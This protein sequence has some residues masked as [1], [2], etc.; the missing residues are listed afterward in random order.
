MMHG[1]PS[2]NLL[3]EAIACLR[4]FAQQQKELL[5]LVSGVEAAPCVS[6][7]PRKQGA[8]PRTPLAAKPVNLVPDPVPVAQNQKRVPRTPK[9]HAITG[10]S[11]PVAPSPVQHV[12]ASPKVAHL[13]Q[14]H[15]GQAPTPVGSTTPSSALELKK[16]QQPQSQPQP[17]V[18]PPPVPAD[19]GKKRERD[20]V[21]AWAK[22]E[23]IQQQLLL[24]QNLDPDTIFAPISFPIPLHEIFT[25]PFKARKRVRS[26]SANWTFDRFTRRDE[27][28]Y[29]RD[30]GWLA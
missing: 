23:E 10:Q 11:T 27:E 3:H 29:K 25:S 21:P 17:V 26:S 6:T 30:M 18:A 16:K 19:E 8:K 4:A 12:A 9:Q 24:N 15:S 13:H 20:Q 5:L 28:Q 1:Q 7:P 14:S 2:V 22:P